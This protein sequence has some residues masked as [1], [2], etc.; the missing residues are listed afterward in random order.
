MMMVACSWTPDFH[1][2]CTHSFALAEI[3]SHPRLDRY[4]HINEAL[5]E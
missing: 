1:L 4:L 5:P 3:H 2:P